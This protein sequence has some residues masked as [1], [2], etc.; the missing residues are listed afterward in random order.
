MSTVYVI[1]GPDGTGKS[2]VAAAL[3]T[4]IGVTSGP[5]VDPGSTT[6]GQHLRALCIDPSVEVSDLSR[7]FMFSAARAAAVELGAS[8]VSRGEDVVYDRLWPST[9]AYQVFGSGLP[10]GLV[11]AATAPTMRPLTD[12]PADFVYVFLTAPEELR[13]RRMVEAG[14][15]PDY[16]ESKGTEFFQS[17]EEGYD[18]AEAHVSMFVPRCQGYTV[19]MSIDAT[20]PL[21]EVV[22][23]ILSLASPSR[24]DP[25]ADHS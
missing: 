22:E 1:E 11:A 23:T 17:V 18:F 4:A 8:R 20:P 21:E 7:L 6:L 13:R 25:H 10:V 14:R 9:V 5:I 24:K 19:T 3:A 12:T 16:F 2:S 15:S